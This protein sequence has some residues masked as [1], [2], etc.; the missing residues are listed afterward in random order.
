MTFTHPNITIGTA[1]HIDHGKTSLIRFLTGCDTDSLR[2]EK[3]R[4]MTIELGHV[5]CSVGEYQVGIVDVPGHEAFIKTMVA[6]ANGMDGVIFVVAADDGIMPQTKEHL[7]I[8]TL[9][10]IKHGIVALTKSDRVAAEDLPRIQEQIRYFLQGTFLEKS[11]IFPVNNLNGDG[12]LEF[13]KGLLQLI[14]EIPPRKVDGIF[15]MPIEKAFSIPGSG[16]IIIG[17]PVSGRITTN[18]TLTL[19]PTQ[20]REGR[21]RQI[22]AYDQ[23]TQEALSGQCAAINIPSFLLKDIKRG[24]V[25]APKGLLTTNW[26]LAEIRLLPQEDL[27]IT[28]SQKVRLHVG[29]SDTQATIYLLDSGSELHGGDQ[30]FVQIH[31]Q[32]PLTIASGDRFIIRSLTPS[33]SIGG[34]SFLRSN[35]NRLR[36]YE[37]DPDQLE[38]CKTAIKDP[39]EWVLYCLENSP[40]ILLSMDDL[41]KTSNIPLEQLEEI[42]TRLKEEGAVYGSLT[43]TLFADSKYKEVSEKIIYSIERYHRENKESLGASVVFLRNDT[44]ISKPAFSAII[45][46]MLSQR[47]LKKISGLISLFGHS[48]EVESQDQKLLDHISNIFKNHLFTP[49]KTQELFE[50]LG[51]VPLSRI[52]KSLVILRQQGILIYVGEHLQFHRD[53]IETAKKLFREHIKQQGSLFSVDAKYVINS[54][55]KYAIPILDYLDKVDFFIRDGN[56]RFLKH[57]EE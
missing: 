49:P 24:Y 21:I 17:I 37:I 9:L 26:F 11:P 27:T 53:A 4:H 55:R 46:L 50:L 12:F 57:S 48:P 39:K 44:Q 29:T 2:E 41:C 34:G 13:H 19:Y 18:Q 40:Q 20:K 1:G 16:T 5:A 23:V 45:D 10:G 33:R 31:T 43:T 38:Q 47:I 14:K 22:R 54:S 6:G 42:V 15:R 8:L 52:E 30:A 35:I 3:E 56:T 28:N 25:L 7:D 32:Q 36:R 51:N